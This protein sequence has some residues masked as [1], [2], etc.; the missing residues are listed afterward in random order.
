MKNLNVELFLAIS[1]KKIVKHEDIFRDLHE[2]KVSKAD[3]FNLSSLHVL[4]LKFNASE[5]YTYNS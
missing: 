5:I 1:S 2:L 3:T 4:E